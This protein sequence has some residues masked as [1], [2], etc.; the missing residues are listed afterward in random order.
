MNVGEINRYI[1]GNTLEY[2]VNIRI[3]IERKSFTNQ[4]FNIIIIVF[5]SILM[6]IWCGK[7]HAMFQNAA[8]DQ[9]KDDRQLL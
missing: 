7:V 4:L 3:K 8:F 2:R 6:P 1:K 5:L 9:Y